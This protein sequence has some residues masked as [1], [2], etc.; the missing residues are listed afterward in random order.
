MTLICV[1]LGRPPPF[2]V[3]SRRRWW[4]RRRAFA[5]VRSC[6]RVA[7]VLETVGRNVEERC[8]VLVPLRRNQYYIL[9]PLGNPPVA[10]PRI[11]P[12]HG[13]RSPY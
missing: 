10:K 13:P 11:Y 6:V 1:A 8:C 5:L 9:T 7:A 3:A 12:V 4:W 2:P